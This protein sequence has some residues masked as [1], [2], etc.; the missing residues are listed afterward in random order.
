MVTKLMLKTMFDKLLATSLLSCAVFTAHASTLSIEAT[1][2]KLKYTTEISNTV[3]KT[4]A[5]WTV[6]PSPHAP[7][8]FQVGQI[9]EMGVKNALFLGDNGTNFNFDVNLTGIEYGGIRSDFNYV[10]ATSETGIPS[11]RVGTSEV[12][13]GGSHSMYSNSM[14][15]SKTSGVRPNAFTVVRPVFE[16]NTTELLDHLVN[17]AMGSGIYR[18][19]MPLTYKYKVQY[20]KDSP[21]AYEIRTF[22]F[23]I[24]VKYTG[25]FLEN[26]TVTG[27]GSITPE[28]VGEFNTRV[29]GDASYTVTATG[30]LP[31]GIT[32][33]FMRDNGDKYHLFHEDD[34]T[35]F[36][37]YNVKCK[38]RS[39]SSVCEENLVVDGTLAVPHKTVVQP[40]RGNEASFSFDIEASI[41]TEYVPSGMYRDDF[42]IVFEVVI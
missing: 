3:A 19:N 11:V 17:E 8:A 29:I 15:V 10:P 22:N 25:V 12:V 4:T 2:T 14:Y 35:K 9:V 5:D 26:I 39:A 16:L 27:S 20:E 21:W 41:D 6:I 33:E 40:T 7:H 24:E 42:I 36:I 18:F 31:D 38:P 1:G 37:P 28:K 13:T 32:M 34:N 30:L 23:G